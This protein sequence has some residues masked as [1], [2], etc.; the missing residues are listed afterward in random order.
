MSRLWGGSG[1][2]GWVAFKKNNYTRHHRYHDLSTRHIASIYPWK[3]LWLLAQ[4]K[5]RFNAPW[6]GS[7]WEYIYRWEVTK[8]VRRKFLVDQ[9]GE[10]NKWQAFER[11]PMRVSRRVFLLLGS[12]S[13][14]IS[15]AWL[16]DFINISLQYNVRVPITLDLGARTK[17]KISL[18]FVRDSLLCARCTVSRN[19]IQRIS[20]NV[21][22]FY[23]L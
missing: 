7:I 2:S 16:R 12:F 3:D 1:T 15:Y 8:Q 9:R 23:T 19:I 5:I 6:S 4:L 14:E 22:I 17:R 20:S 11:N 18:I 21:I 13:C 10:W